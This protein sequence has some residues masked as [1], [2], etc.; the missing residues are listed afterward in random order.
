MN[1]FE[2]L[3]SRKSVRSYTGEQLTEGQVKELLK[4]AYASP[5][6][7]ARYDTLSLTVIQDKAFLDALD[8]ATAVANGDENSHP[9]YGAPTLI[10]VSSVIG[11]KPQ[12]NVNYSNAAIIV[13]NMSLAAVELGLG[14]CH[15]WGA[16]RVLNKSP[17]L[18]EKLDLP[19]GMVPCCGLIVGKSSESYEIRP[20]KE[21]RIQTKF[22]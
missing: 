8:K 9:L 13:Q 12:D 14:T 16:I 5:V 18:L 17:E 3:Y 20:V 22:M 1:T 21:D 7:R 15:I 11:E 4:A 10:L 6:G 19:D 2:N